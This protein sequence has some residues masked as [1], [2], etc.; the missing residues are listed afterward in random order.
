MLFLTLYRFLAGQ[1]F[2]FSEVKNCYSLLNNETNTNTA[3]GSNDQIRN[4]ETQ[5]GQT[6]VGFES[7]MTGAAYK[8]SFCSLSE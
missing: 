3:T 5:E 6:V 2:Y 4:V 7:H 1:I 8:K